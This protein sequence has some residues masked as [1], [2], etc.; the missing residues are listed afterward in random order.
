MKRNVF[1]NLITSKMKQ[2]VSPLIAQ[3]HELHKQRLTKVKATI[4][5]KKPRYCSNLRFKRKKILTELEEKSEI[6][7]C[8][9]ILLDKMM[10]ID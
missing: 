5:N 6:Q 9:D 2:R 4:D 8:N 1:S 7:R 3:E 10:V